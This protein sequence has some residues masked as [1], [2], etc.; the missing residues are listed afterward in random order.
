MLQCIS[1]EAQTTGKVICDILNQIS[2]SH[3]IEWKKC[4]DVCTD[5]VMPMTRKT[6]GVMA[7]IKTASKI[8]ASSHR[9]VW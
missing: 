5:S 6:A 3:Q 1:V 4:T 9:I 7:C 2:L 8:C